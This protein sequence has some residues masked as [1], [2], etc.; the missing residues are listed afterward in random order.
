[1]TV[2]DDVAAV[3]WSTFAGAPRHSVW[4][5][6]HWTP[7]AGDPTPE[8]IIAA[9]TA[10]GPALA[11]FFLDD[12]SMTHVLAIDADAADGWNVVATVAAVL[13]E[14]GIAG[15]GERSRRGGHLWIVADRVMPAIVGRFALMTAIE[16][17]GFDPTDP[18]IELRPDRDRR[19]SPF[20]GAS[21]RAPW[22]AHPE[23]GERFGLLDMT[24]G[25]ALG[26]KIATALIAL[27][28]ADHRAIG[29]LAEQY[30]PPVRIVVTAPRRDRDEGSITAVLRQRFG[31]EDAAGKSIEAGKSIVCPFHDDTGPSLTIAKDDRRA[32]CHSP[33]CEAHENGRGITPW[34]AAQLAGVSA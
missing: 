22:M 14:Q 4:S 29:E 26:G 13:A 2:A 20:A 25:R 32:W 10:D 11:P 12:E 21:L 24:T 15:Y 17:A 16:R 23:T 5:G 19:T 31:P 9:L 7:T 28:L 30:R 34:K 18:K 33:R 1:V 6:E 27:E 8:A 3:Y